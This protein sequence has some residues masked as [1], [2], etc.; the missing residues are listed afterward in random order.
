MVHGKADHDE[1]MKPLE[2]NELWRISIE[3]LFTKNRVIH[4]AD[5]SLKTLSKK[6]TV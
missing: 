5:P 6:G 1:T 3:V 2:Q 4:V